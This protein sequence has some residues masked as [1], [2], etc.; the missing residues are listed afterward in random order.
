MR[1][2][3]ETARSSP[4]V[5]LREDDQAIL[6]LIGGPYRAA[7]DRGDAL[8]LHLEEITGAGRRKHQRRSGLEAEGLT[9]EEIRAEMAQLDKELERLRRELSRVYGPR[10]QIVRADRARERLAG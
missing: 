7:V 8:L 1:R 5:C 2:T 4:G 3:R 10:S 6:D 9:V